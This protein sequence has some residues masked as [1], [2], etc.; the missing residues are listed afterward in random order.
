MQGESQT[1]NDVYY[2]IL[3][4]NEL[5]SIQ[6]T[7]KK[8]LNLTESAKLVINQDFYYSTNGL[9]GDQFYDDTD[10]TSSSEYPYEFGDKSSNNS[11]TATSDSTS[12][13][14]EEVVDNANQ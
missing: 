1:I 7:L 9:L 14:S 8:Q 10:Y 2:Q 5:L 6:N 4:V 13:D 12:Q 3:G 11:T